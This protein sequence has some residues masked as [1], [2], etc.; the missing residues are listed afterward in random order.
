MKQVKIPEATIGRLS[1]YSRFLT[2]LEND[3]IE[4]VSSGEIAK[5][6]AGNSA[7][8]RKDFAYFGGF[9]KRGVGYNVADLNRNIKEILGLNREWKAVIVG[10]G[11]LG[12]ALAYYHGFAARGFRIIGLFDNNPSKKGEKI[13][14]LE[15]Q[16]ASELENFLEKNPVDIAILTLPGET[17]QFVVDRVV[18]KGIKGILNFAPVVVFTEKDVQVRNVDLSVNLEILSYNLNSK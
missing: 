13:N 16:D 9:G 10:M 3:G 12:R 2:K 1:F 18:K 8:V 11:N 17:V 5:G 14:N 7:Q 4:T 15:I 6:I